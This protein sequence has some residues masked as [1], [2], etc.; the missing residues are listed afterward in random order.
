MVMQLRKELQQLG[1]ERIVREDEFDAAQIEF[2][3]HRRHA[4]SLSQCYSTP[5]AFAA[6][7]DALHCKHEQRVL[8]AGKQLQA[9]I[10][11]IGHE[12]GRLREVEAELPLTFVQ[13]DDFKQNGTSDGRDMLNFWPEGQLA[14]KFAELEQ[15]HREVV[16]RAS[17]VQAE[18]DEA[19]RKVAKIRN[20]HVAEFP[21]EADFMCPIT[22]ERMK[23]PVLAADAHTY[24][25]VA[26][27]KWMQSHNTS[28]M[29]GA[30]LAHRYLTQ[31][32]AL[33][34]IIE[35]YEAHIEQIDCASSDA[36][37]ITSLVSSGSD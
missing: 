12:R 24:E 3:K 8:E 30:A 20:K 36:G 35:S 33:R 17:I 21:A 2:R 26:I 11:Q 23:E 10:V 28:P 13:V 25:R 5:D 22:H 14:W 37:S 9:L 31:N 4:Q 29:T 6:A 16:L 18:R 15:K 19:L 1:T 27:E 34:R 32:F 7:P